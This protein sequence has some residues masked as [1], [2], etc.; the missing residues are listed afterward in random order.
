M[1]SNK[2][3]L[4]TKIK[5]FELFILRFE[6]LKVYLYEYTVWGWVQLAMR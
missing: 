3:S 2:P 6:V 5:I 1:Y 4:G